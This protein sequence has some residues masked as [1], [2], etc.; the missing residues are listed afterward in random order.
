MPL[1]GFLREL[2]NKV[3]HDLLVLPSAAVAIHDEGGRILMGLHSDRRIWVV[4]G[5]LIE[6]GET[7]ADAAVR[8]T[9]E[10]TGLLIELTSVLGVYGGRE[11]LVEYPNGD[12]ASYI[13]TVFRGRVAGGQMRPDREEILDLR[14]V[15][16]EE[17][18][19]LPHA[20]W[21]D[22]AVNAMFSTEGP[23]DFQHANWKPEED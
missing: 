20:A 22:L 9:W 21:L 11:L 10:E 14:Y 16:R 2:R 1:A 13:G 4:P 15:S 6:P 23:V 18:E 3:G 8:E 7:P 5:G 12:R 17:L 19:T